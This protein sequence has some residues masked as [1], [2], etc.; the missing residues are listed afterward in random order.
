[1]RIF[2]KKTVGLV[3]TAAVMLSTGGAANAASPAAIHTEVAAK[4]AND[5]AKM[6]YSSRDIISFFVLR[7][8][9]LFESH[10]D[11]ATQL[12]MTYQTVPDSVI[13]EVVAEFEAFDPDFEKKVAVPIQSGNPQRAQKA[14]EHL[15]NDL[16]TIVD[17]KG[18]V[19]AL[20]TNSAQ[21]WFK[22]VNYVAT[23]QVAAAGAVVLALAVVAAGAVLV[24][25]YEP[26]DA[27]TEFEREFLA[28]SVADAL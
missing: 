7:T 2:S 12:G 25:L 22:T 4:K 5:A 28:L 13:D 19:S 23:A 14:L 20:G 18:S 17:A 3:L 24:L 16:T 21:G 8:G 1:M 26:S 15:S 6:K 27:S 11:L 10:A 9:P